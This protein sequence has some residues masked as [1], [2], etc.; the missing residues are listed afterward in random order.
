MTI[1]RLNTFYFDF[2]NAPTPLEIDIHKWFRSQGVKDGEAE[3]I[4][5]GNYRKRVAL[6]LRQ[7]ETFIK[8]LDRFS[9]RGVTYCKD[10]ILYEIPYFAINLR[11]SLPRPISPSLSLFSQY[12]KILSNKWDETNH[13]LD[14]YIK[15]THRQTMVIEMELE[16][17]IPSFIYIEG[18]KLK[19]NY[20]G[21]P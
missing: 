11:K 6:K 15:A 1:V 9:E 10:A 16:R 21:Q 7:S 13:T 4:N 8:L 3:V 20:L 17:N 12:G 19:I 5:H 14:E 2:R 18:E